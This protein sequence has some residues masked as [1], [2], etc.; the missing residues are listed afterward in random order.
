MCSSQCNLLMLWFLAVFN[1]ECRLVVPLNFHFIL[2]LVISIKF[3]LY[4]VTL[5]NGGMFNNK[6]CFRE[7]QIIMGLLRFYDTD[8]R[9]Y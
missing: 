6:S 2:M 4:Q 8:E 9:L 7:K 5:K 3:I 1:L